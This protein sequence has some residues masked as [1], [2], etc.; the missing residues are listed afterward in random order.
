MWIYAQD[1]GYMSRGGTPFVGYSGTGEGKNNPSMQNLR[2]I[3]PLPCGFY[4]IE[5]PVD[6]PEHG[7][8]ALPLVPDRDNTMFGRSDFM[9]HGDSIEHPGAA[10]EGC[11]ILDRDA[12]QTIWVSNDKVLQV[13]PSEAFVSDAE[14]GM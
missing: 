1:T 7:P 8:F 2:D 4:T 6:S 14:L 3:G 9:I 13:I 12:R 10:S 11:I 5:P